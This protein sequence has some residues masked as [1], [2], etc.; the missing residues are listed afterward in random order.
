MRKFNYLILT[1]AC[2]IFFRC[3]ASIKTIHSNPDFKIK[4]IHEKSISILPTVNGYFGYGLAELF[5]EKFNELQKEVTFIKTSP[6]GAREL[7]EK[8][9]EIKKEVS[10]IALKIHENDNPDKL[11]EEFGTGISA[12]VVSA[13]EF[14]AYIDDKSR[15][16]GL[17]AT[18]IELTPEQSS[19]LIKLGTDYVVLPYLSS[20]SPFFDKTQ[21]WFIFFPIWF[22][23]ATYENIFMNFYIFDGKSG[24]YLHS[25]KMTESRGL[26]S[27][28]GQVDQI[29]EKVLHIDLGIKKQFGKK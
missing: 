26:R 29:I 11:K 25:V 21:M 20:Y 27:L 23:N 5:D 10:E 8:E 14:N 2:L 9:Q 18:P 12:T 6:A 17:Q 3:G 4:S 19:A 22:K 1:F 24:K 7:F 28:S 16:I 15:L 13:S